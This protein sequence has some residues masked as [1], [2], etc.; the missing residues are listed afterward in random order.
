MKPQVIA[1]IVLVVLGA[2][3]LFTG[4][5]SFG[6]QRSVMRVGDVEVSAEEQRVIPA[7]VGGVAIVGGLLLVGTGVRKRA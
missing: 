7:W 2:L 3:V 6:S 1:G 4:G 5:L